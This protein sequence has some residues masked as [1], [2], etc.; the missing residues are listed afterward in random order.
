MVPLLR[1]GRPGFVE[2]IK[3]PGLGDEDIAQW[4]HLPNR[5]ALGSIPSTTHESKF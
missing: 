3:G 4:Q 2:K 1:W 5:E